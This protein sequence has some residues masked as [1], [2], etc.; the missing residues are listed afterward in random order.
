MNRSIVEGENVWFSVGYS[1]QKNLS[2]TLRRHE[3]SKFHLCR[4]IEHLQGHLR[5]DVM[6]QKLN[7][8][9]CN[10][11]DSQELFKRLIDA[12]VFLESRSMMQQHL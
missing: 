10:Q 6:T 9:K 11:R 5:I 7:V 8:E 1:E 4:T 2:Q 3:T 12:V